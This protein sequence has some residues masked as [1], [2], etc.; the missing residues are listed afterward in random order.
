MQIFRRQN[1]HKEVELV[2][3][4]EESDQEIIE[5]DRPLTIDKEAGLYKDSWQSEE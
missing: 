5:S 2:I 4:E 1:L 3:I